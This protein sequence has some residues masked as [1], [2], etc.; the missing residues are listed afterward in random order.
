MNP[1]LLQRLEKDGLLSDLDRHFARFMVRLSG[2]DAPEVGL[3]A[4]LV[5]RDRRRGHVC[6][7]LSRISGNPPEEFPEAPLFP[8]LAP[9]REALKGSR[10]VGRPGTFAPLILDDADR[11]YLYRY[12]DYQRRLAESLLAR[13]R[14]TEEGGRRTEI[15]GALLDSYFPSSGEAEGPDRQR[16]AAEVAL[17]RQLCVISGGPGTGKTTTVA[18]ILAL[19]VATSEGR[20]PAVALAAPTG[21]AAARMQEAIQ[22][23]KTRPIFDAVRDRLPDAAGT[24][25]RLLGTVPGSPYFRH[26]RDAPLPAD[27]VVID[28]ASMVDMA[29]MAKLVD[30][31]KPEARLILLGDRD[32]LASVE[33]GAVL[34]DIC[35][36]GKPTPETEATPEE[37]RAGI[38][39]CIV[40]LEKSY[41]FT[42][43][44]GIGAASRAV[45]RGDAEAALAVLEDGGPAAEWGGVL[46]PDAPQARFKAAVIEGFRAY[47]EARHDPETVF[48]RFDAFRILCGLRQGP[49]GAAV[50]NRRVEAILETAGLIRP[51]TLW[52]PGRPVMITR[53][54]YG[55]GLFNGD[56][57]VALR[58]PE[59]GGEVRVFFPGP[60]GGVRRLNPMRLPDHETVYAMTVH[61]SQGSE[62]NH[63]ALLLPDRDAPVLTRELIYTGL[64]RARE[65]VAV[66]GDPAVFRRAVERRIR[67]SSGL[68]DALWGGGQ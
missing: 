2:G 50:V 9:W 17:T 43:A 27:V 54:D 7:D 39:G 59:A 67:R 46:D 21:K 30:A 44:G 33:A 60:D 12:W 57:G 47:L 14:K 29:L 18:R 56:V 55:L 1:D 13:G 35:N 49:F 61:K 15:L 62:F 53:N 45:N 65:S 28:E 10:V 51:S 24:I 19:F 52:Y 6:L 22:R 4:A 20:P 42:A 64:T 5:S 31:L 38:R 34:G 37:T 63:V 16:Q 40:Q 23:E 66:W 25:H 41:R 11:L 26:H 36:T 8:G 58:D 3:A 68:R 48:R 32:Q